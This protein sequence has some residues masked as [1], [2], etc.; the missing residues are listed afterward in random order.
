MSCEDVRSALSVFDLCEDTSDGA[1]VTTHCL[2][3]SFEPVHVFVAK[4]GDGFKVHDGGGAFLAAWV[5]GRDESLINAALKKEC[6]RFHL[7]LM[8]QSCVAEVSSKDWL[9]S[10]ILGVANAS[11]VA[12]TNAVSK[13]VSVAES[14]LVDRIQQTLIETVGARG[15]DTGV[16]LI[17]KS[18]GSRHFDFAVKST[19]DGEPILING[20][21]P[22]RGSIS[23]KYVAFADTDGDQ[24]HKFAVYDRQLE[25]DD[26]ALLQQVASIL[27]LA[28]LS[29]NAK[30]VISHDA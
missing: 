13:L 18:G 3:P 5:H 9:L 15:F 21:A 7:A 14:A 30:R 10:A 26:V 1:R 28:A 27:P 12:A 17:G 4:V 16:D 6:A 11:A 22:H 25:T 23:H 24:S 29:R 8:G 20:V 19:H 2:Y